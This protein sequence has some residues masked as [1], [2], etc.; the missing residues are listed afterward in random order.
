MRL[1]VVLPN[2]SPMMP[3]ARLTDIVVAAEELGFHTAWLPDHLLPPGPYGDVYGGVYEPL[4]TLAHLAARTAT[5]RLGTSVLVLP[6]RAPLV[7]A[8]QAATLHRLSAGRL[9]LGLGVGWERAEF[10]AVG[11]DFGTRGARTDEAITL[12]RRLFAGADGAF[13][14]RFHRF[15]H[16]VF[17]PRTDGDPPRIMTGGWSDAALRR[18]AALA[19]EWQGVGSDV[20]AFTRAAA[21]IREAASRP[22]AV[23]SRIGWRGDDADLDATVRVLRTFAQAGADH[24]AIWFGAHRGTE[25]RMATLLRALE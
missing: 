3:P 21:T 18:A 15:D 20:T 1:D 25:E 10:D 8:K 16:G 11:V 23:G 17:E 13:A 7:V 5:I 4:V 22:V 9:T 6:L 14:G 19:D 24:L 12:L 2:E